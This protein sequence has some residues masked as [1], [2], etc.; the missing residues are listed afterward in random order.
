MIA[1]TNPLR[2]AEQA[3]VAHHH[4]SVFG[5]FMQQTPEALLSLNRLLLVH[6]FTT[7][8]ELGTHDGGLSTFFALYCL[9]SRMPAQ[10]ENPN[11]PSLYKNGT[12]HKRPKTFYTFDNVERDI[13]RGKLLAS[14]GAQV[15]KGDTL[16]DERVIEVI[17]EVIQSPGT[18]LLLC[19]GG[20]KRKE[21]ALYAPA[22]KPGDFI[23]VHDW[24]KDAAAM[25]SLRERGV[26]TSWESWMD[27]GPSDAV[28]S[29][30]IGPTIRENGVQQVY[31]EEFDDVAWFCARK[32]GVVK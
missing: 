8:I 23:M 5:S 29:V 17:R 2:A 28:P 24:A 20:D 14:M 12:H 31:A 13:P 30:G 22:L 6:D 21:V 32:M 18:T 25:A 7:I 9:G 19:D 4:V 10:A 26:W 16:N 27:E 11:E 1:T 15:C 3:A